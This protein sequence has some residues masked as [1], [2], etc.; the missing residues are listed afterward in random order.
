MAVSKRKKGIRGPAIDP[1][2]LFLKHKKKV[3]T[4]RFKELY[5]SEKKYAQSQGSDL[6][7][8]MM[9][10]RIGMKNPNNI[11]KWMELGAAKKKTPTI[12]FRTLKLMSIALDCTIAE[13]IDESHPRDRNKT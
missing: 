10:K 5:E 8:E 6:T 13:L 4:I 11:A 2:S 3:P 9:A 1:D 12:T 7:W